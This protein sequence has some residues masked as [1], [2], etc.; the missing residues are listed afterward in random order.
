MSESKIHNTWLIRLIVL[1]VILALFL[2]ILFSWPLFAWSPLKI[3]Y[4]GFNYEMYEVFVDDEIPNEYD[5]DR[6]SELFSDNEK[7]HQLTY[8]KKVSIFLCKDLEKIQNCF[9][10]IRINASGFTINTADKVFI[11]LSKM[12]ETGLD[13]YELI[14]HE[15]SHDLIF[16]NM[17]F[18][19]TFELSQWFR[20][21]IAVYFG[22]PRY[23]EAI[24]LKENLHK[25]RIEYNENLEKLYIYEPNGNR[26]MRYSYILYGWFVEYLDINYG[27][28]KLI[29][30]IHKTM[31]SP[32]QIRDIFRDQYSENLINVFET[33]KSTLPY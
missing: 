15:S 33:F 27:R 18:L 5:L 23:K 11:N 10:L 6:I 8:K 19:K 22:G 12:N 31:K 4:K 30:F 32:Q 7:L 26:N 14:K 9:P 25:M 29:K 17:D 3:G 2:V 1:P 16:Q 24:P 28:N 13:I 20:E 21:G